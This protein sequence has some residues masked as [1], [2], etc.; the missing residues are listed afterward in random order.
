[1]TVFNYTKVKR[2]EKRLYTLFNTTI[3]KTGI[4]TNTIYTCVALVLVFFLPGL[5]VCKLTGTFW[6]NPLMIIST[7]SAGYFWLVFI[8]APIA[9]GVSLNSVKI[10]IYKMID[11]IKMYLSPKQPIDHNGK[12]VTLDGYE[13]DAFVDRI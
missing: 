9:L 7:S 6:Y 11:Y 2:R 10:Q 1:M 8:F 3:S 4:V 5:L 12:R 13:I